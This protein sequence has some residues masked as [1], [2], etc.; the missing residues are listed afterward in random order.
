[1]CGWNRGWDLSDLQTRQTRRQRGRR[2]PDGSFSVNSQ[3]D[4]EYF[5]STV[6]TVPFVCVTAKYRC[7]CEKRIHFEEDFGATM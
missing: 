3:E 7:V 6:L 5:F 4:L 1:M 2:E